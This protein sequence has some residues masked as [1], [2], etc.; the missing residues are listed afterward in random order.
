MKIY[1]KVTNK[2]WTSDTVAVKTPTGWEPATPER[3]APSLLEWLQHKLIGH[4]SFGQ[5]YCV[6]CGLTAIMPPH[7]K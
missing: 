5:P 6:Q 1:F 4:Y 2:V 7:T 3:Y